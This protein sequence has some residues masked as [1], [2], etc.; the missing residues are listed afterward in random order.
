M[1]R[2]VG[3]IERAARVLVGL[4]LLAIGIFHVVVGTVAV[5]AYIFGT[6]ALATAIFAYCPAW[7]AFGINTSRSKQIHAK[8]AG[9]GE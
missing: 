4:A 7:T 8:A 2:N 3:G 9:S 6:I 1:M 5:F